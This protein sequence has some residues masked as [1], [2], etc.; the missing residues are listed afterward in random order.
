MQMFLLKGLARRAFQNDRLP[1][2][3]YG[4]GSPA[5]PRTWRLWWRLW[6]Q[7][8][9]DRAS[10]V[11]TGT[12]F[13]VSNRSPCDAHRG[14]AARSPRPAGRCSQ[15]RRE[16]MRPVN[17]SSMIRPRTQAAPT[18]PAERSVMVRVRVTEVWSIFRPDHRQMPKPRRI[19][20]AS[21]WS[22]TT[23]ISKRGLAHLRV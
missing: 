23:C 10:A 2:R 3:H 21:S 6:Y 12:L 9:R 7:G 4:S 5:P 14:I 22:A 17:G 13:L 20:E 15:C 11:T 8:L 18:L 19:A 1:P 16:I